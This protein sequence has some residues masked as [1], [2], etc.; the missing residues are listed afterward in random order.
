MSYRF[1]PVITSC[2]PKSRHSLS[3]ATP[4]ACYW[5]L[6]LSPASTAGRKAIAWRG[7]C[8]W[9]SKH[10]SI[11]HGRIQMIHL[12]SFEYERIL[13]LIFGVSF[14]K[15]G[16]FQISS[17]PWKP[18]CAPGWAKRGRR[19]TAPWRPR[20][21]WPSARWT[22]ISAAARSERRCCLQFKRDDFGW[23]STALSWKKVWNT[24]NKTKNN[25]KKNNEEVFFR[26]QTCSVLAIIWHFRYFPDWR[27][28]FWQVAVWKTHVPIVC[29][30]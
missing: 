28:Q 12:R 11:R 14:F 7:R 1:M 29:W 23:V 4:R 8:S 6:G 3:K 2:H 21:C 16:C 25:G 17:A 30:P 13:D 20:P 9:A 5:W 24:R 22:R 27:Y 10:P 19:R 26:I 15:L 18:S